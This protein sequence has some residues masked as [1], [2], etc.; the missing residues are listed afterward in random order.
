MPTVRVTP[1]RPTVACAPRTPNDR[2]GPDFARLR[3]TPGNNCDRPWDI[4]FLPSGKMLYTENDR[5]TISAYMGPGEPRRVLG[6]L[7]GVDPNGEG[8]LMGLAVDPAFPARPY[9]YVCMSIVSPSQ[10]RV[11]RI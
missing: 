4:A 11:L 7:A 3:R 10:N 6:T 2:L 9:L 8:G 5:G 1:R